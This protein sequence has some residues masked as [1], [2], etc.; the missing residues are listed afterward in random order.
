MKID[1]KIRHFM[2][3]WG[4]SK[5]SIYDI[6]KKNNT[7]EESKMEKNNRI[8]RKQN[9]KI[10]SLYRM[11]SLD[12]IFYYAIEFLFL[13]QVKNISAADV[14]LKSSFY[15]LFMIILQ[16]PATIVVEKLGTRRCTILGNIFNVIYLSLIIFSTN[17]EMLVLA[18]FIS[19][20][21]F[22]LKDISDTTLLTQ[23]IPACSKKGEIFSKLEGRGS[24]NYYYINAVTSVLA[25][26]LYVINPFIPVIFALLVTILATIMSFGFQEIEN[27]ELKNE[28]NKSRNTNISIISYIKELKDGFKFVIKSRRLRSLMLYSGIIWGAFCLISTYRTSLLKDIGTQ[29]QL[30]AI[31]SAIVGIA[32]GIGA[33]G[34]L[35]FHKKYRNKSFSIILIITSIMTL[36]MGFV[37]ITNISFV[38]MVVII[39]L[40]NIIIKLL[41]G[42]HRS[43][44]F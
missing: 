43:F 20:I 25:G 11:L 39:T 35:Y 31:I 13:T 40:A 23:S 10:Y 24:K 26:F 41:Q 30:I 18:E 27:E 34:Q 17:F 7:K 6:K 4:L 2:I 36:I 32:S 44:V 9:M 8:K 1:Y 15:A 38:Y 21:C 29:E 16:I 3:Y 5:K 22:S 19:A 37:G 12:R 14:V 42:I 28:D 33:N